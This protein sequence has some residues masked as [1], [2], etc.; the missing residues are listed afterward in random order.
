MCVRVCTN[1]YSIIINSLELYNNYNKKEKK[2]G[3]SRSFHLFNMFA[4]PRLKNKI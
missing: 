1:G 4:C 2:R 3:N